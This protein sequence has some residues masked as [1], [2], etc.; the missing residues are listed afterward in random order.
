MSGS[1]DKDKNENKHESLSVWTT[2]QFLTSFTVKKQNHPPQTA[3]TH[4]TRN[5][6][7]MHS[8]PPVHN[9]GDKKAWAL[10][11][12]PVSTLALGKDN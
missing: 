8:K 10:I 11:E 12:M 7:Y 9:L 2:L 6:Q 5:P 1:C 4:R 3:L